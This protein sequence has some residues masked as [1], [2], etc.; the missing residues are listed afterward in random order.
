MKQQCFSSLEN[1]RKLL[2]N[3]YKTLWTSYKNGN[4]KGFNS[5]KQ[6]WKWIFK[7]RNKKMVRYWQ[8]IKW[9]L[10]FTSRCNEVFNKINRIISLRLFWCIYSCYRKYHLYIINIIYYHLFAVERGD[11]N[12]K[13]AFK[14]CAA[15]RKCK[16]EMNDTYVDEAE[17]IDVEIP[18]Y[19]LIEYIWR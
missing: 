1:Q 13:V 15:F 11:N 5:A 18:M 7:I 10:L 6:F 17:F 8:W 12:T 2:L 9:W 14:N 16:T 4:T 19:N 3:F